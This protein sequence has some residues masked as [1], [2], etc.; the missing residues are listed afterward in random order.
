M[1]FLRVKRKCE[2]DP[3]EVLI[4][5]SKKHKLQDISDHVPIFE[6]ARSLVKEEDINDVIAKTIKSHDIKSPKCNVEK[7]RTHMRTENEERIKNN[8]YH[9]YAALRKLDDTTSEEEAVP[10]IDVLDDG[11]TES[12]DQSDCVYDLYYSSTNVDVTDPDFI[13]NH[14]LH[15]ISD[16]YDWNG[17]FES[18]DEVGASDEDDSNDEN[19][20]RND[21]PDEDSS[22]EESD[23][24]LAKQMRKTRFFSDGSLSSSDYDECAY[25]DREDY[26]DA[27]A[28]GSSSDD[29]S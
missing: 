1:A 20:W 2:E 13:K 22:D 5:A 29:E 17:Q 28:G 8:R 12:E 14:V 6:L 11:T 21:Y 4:L 18:E 9:L 10:V 23:D 24:S 7:L 15:E 27:V 25:H 19:N 3:K 26:Y 16:E